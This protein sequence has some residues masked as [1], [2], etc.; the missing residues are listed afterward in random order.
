MQLEK[1]VDRPVASWQKKEVVRD[2][3]EAPGVPEVLK[4]PRE[5]DRQLVDA[6]RATQRTVLAVRAPVSGNSGYGMEYSPLCESTRRTDYALRDGEDIMNSTFKTTYNNT[7]V[8]VL[9][10]LDDH[11]SQA[12]TLQP[13]WK[14]FEDS[15]DESTAEPDH[16][17]MEI[18][19][20][21][22]PVPRGDCQAL[23]KEKDQCQMVLV[24]MAQ[25]QY[26]R[27]GDEAYPGLMFD[28]E[29]DELLKAPFPNKGTVL[30]KLAHLQDE[31]V[32]RA[33]LFMIPKIKKSAK[34]NELIQWL[35]QHPL[36]EPADML[37]VGNEINKTYK[38]IKL[39]GEEAR[40]LERNALATKNWTMSNWLRLYCCAIDDAA[41]P[42]LLVKDDCMEHDELDG[43]NHEERP[44]TW[45]EKIAELYN[46]AKVY[47]TEALPDLHEDFAYQRTLR[48]ADLPGGK[49]T[50][51]D[52]KSRLADARA[53]LIVIISKWERSGNGFGQRDVDDPRFGHFNA[54]KGDCR[55]D[56]VKDTHGQ[57]SHHLY[58]WHLSD[59]MG[60]LK[61]VL[62]VLSQEVAGDSSRCP[63]DLSLTQ[64][65]RARVDAEDPSVVEA[66]KQ[67]FRD[68]ISVALKDIGDGMKQAVAIQQKSV[69]VQEKQLFAASIVTLRAAISEEEDK[70]ERFTFKL[71][72]LDPSEQ[73]GP[74]AELKRLIDRH[75][76]RLKDYDEQMEEKIYTLN[77]MNNHQVFRQA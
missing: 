36:E 41:R 15:S 43:R 4:D 51:Q 13:N 76:L 66:K 29:N 58:L 50:V 69:A 34:K 2:V 40:A 39:L 33:L 27:K 35:K 60:V 21:T 64:K 44:P 7:R 20:A 19:A 56:F 63:V 31:C 3:V 14:E 17:L 73:P 75:D 30:P 53:K 8:E 32:R 67:V 42:F 47:V 71:M 70:L 74:A 59:I 24:A 26:A 68:E 1:P 65:K 9:E 6:L 48:L 38:A 11:S 62:T 28:I 55:A 45:H 46:S 23:W 61:N 72:S 5:I 37:F 52:V 57:K 54:G 18:L 77:K 25:G 22:T 12:T 16:E 10:N 49:I